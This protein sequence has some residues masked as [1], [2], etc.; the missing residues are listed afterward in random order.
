MITHCPDDFTPLVEHTTGVEWR[1]TVSGMTVH[2]FTDAYVRG[3]TM[4][5]ECPLDKRRMMERRDS[6][7]GL[8]GYR[9]QCGFEYPVTRTSASIA[10][11]VSTAGPPLTLAML[12]Q[13]FAQLAGIDRAAANEELLEDLETTDPIVAQRL[14]RL[15]LREYT[16]DWQLRGRADV[17]WEAGEMSA[18]CNVSKHPAPH[19]ANR[20]A[21]DTCYCGINAYKLTTFPDDLQWAA[22]DGLGVNELGVVGIVELGGE[23]HEYARGYRAQH[24]LMLEATVLTPWPIGEWFLE[25]LAE[26]Y[27]CSFRAIPLEEWRT[28]WEVTY[29]RD[30]ETSEK[31]QGT[32]AGAPGATTN[33]GPFTTIT[34]SHSHSVT[35][36]A[37]ASSVNTFAR[38][39]KTAYQ[40]ALLD[41]MFNAGIVAGDPA[42]YLSGKATGQEMKALL[43]FADAVLNDPMHTAD[44]TKFRARRVP[45][46]TRRQRIRKWLFPLGVMSQTSLLLALSVV[47]IVAMIVWMVTP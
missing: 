38:H 13:Q 41:W 45:A 14:W 17:Y 9:C 10:T 8:I 19:W 11:A 39:G 31:D 35:G 32:Q 34:G 20:H 40:T 22:R 27:Q 26:R 21:P 37:G 30:R 2:Q 16:A 6:K 12:Q 33:P 3:S 1:C 47:Y 36:P 25:E 7:G 4:T 18:R 29:G 15:A 42:Y 5:V 44:F 28:E 24:A 23:I 46:P 43:D